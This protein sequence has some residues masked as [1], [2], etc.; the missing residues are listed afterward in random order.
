MKSTNTYRILGSDGF[1]EGALYQ[2]VGTTDG[3]DIGVAAT[4]GE[5][6]QFATAANNTLKTALTPW[7]LVP[8]PELAGSSQDELENMVLPLRHAFSG[9]HLSFGASHRYHCYNN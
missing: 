9:A 5:I 7:E 2:F 4:T 3:L 8:W 6:V 1:T